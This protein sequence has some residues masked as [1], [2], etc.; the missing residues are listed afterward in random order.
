MELS[1]PSYPILVVDDEVSILQSIEITLRTNNY[2]NII[3]IQQSDKV[4]D[5]V[6]ANPVELILLDLT[7]PRVCGEEILREINQE[8][9]GIPVIVIT[10][11]NDVQVAVSCMQLGA[12]DYLLKPVERNRLLSSVNKVVELSNLKRQYSLLKK[13]MLSDTIENQKAFSHIKTQSSTMKSIF[14]Y[15]EAIGKSNESVLIAGETGTGKELFAKAMYLLN[16]YKGNFVTVNAAGLDDNMFSD[17]LFGHVSGAFTGASSRRDGLVEQ[18][19]NGVLFLDEIGDLAY[20]SQVKLLRLIQEKEYYP[21]GADVPRRAEC[22]ILVATNIDLRKKMEEGVFRKDLYY[23]LSVHTI[24]LPP[25]RKRMDDIGV[26]VDHFLGEAAKSMNKTKPTPP[27]ELNC[28]LGS[29]SFPGNVRELRSMVYDAVSQHKSRVMSMSVFQEHISANMGCSI[30]LLRE[31][32]GC[33]NFFHTFENLPPIKSIVD[34]LIQEA[35]ERSDG[36]QSVAAKMLGVSRQ[37]LYS[38]L[39]K[40]SHSSN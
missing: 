12:E 21:L 1:R 26:L 29:Y 9:P 36:N 37:T 22:R 10:G 17:S 13:H 24:K 33:S 5:F 39:K 2:N 38:K 23:R 20:A 31:K 27:A 28:L 35:V 8:F 11:L 7:M 32:V 16:D 25:L 30:P 15:M 34:E 40:S 4:L 6:R 14:Q 18:A 19:K 3:C